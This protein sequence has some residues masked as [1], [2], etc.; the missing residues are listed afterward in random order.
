M[1]VSTAQCWRCRA[2]GVM[3]YRDP[4]MA[5]ND[6]IGVCGVCAHER[7]RIESRYQALGKRLRPVRK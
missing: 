1:P 5:P 7:H 3:L 2:S 4:L 6:R